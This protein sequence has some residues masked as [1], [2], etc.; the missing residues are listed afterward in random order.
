MDATSD[1]NPRAAFPILESLKRY[2]WPIPKR[3]FNSAC[4]GNLKYLC[5]E[6]C[7]HL[8]NVFSLSIA[9]GLVQLQKLE[10]DECDDMEGCFHKE[11]EDEKALNDNIMF[12]QL[13]SIELDSPPRLIGFCT[14]VGPTFNN[15]L[16]PFQN[17]LSHKLFLSNTIL[18]PPNLK[19]LELRKADSQEVV[20]DLKGLNINDNHQRI[21]VLAQL[22]TLEVKDLYKLT[23]VWKNVPIGIQ[24]FQ[25]L[26]SIEVSKCHRLKDIYSQL[27][28]QNCLWNFKALRRRGNGI[29]L[30]PRVGSLK[31]QELP[32]M[33]SLCIKTYSFEWSSIKEIYLHRSP[34][35]KQLVQKFRAK[36]D[37]K[38]SNS[39]K[40]SEIWSFFPSHI[41]ECLKNL[42][43]IELIN[44][45]SLEVL[46]QLEELN[47]E[48]NQW[49]Q[50]LIS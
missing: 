6:K 3:S 33:M 9:R 15:I 36:K 16:A 2:I 39:D 22:K 7:Q 24:G 20:F 29:I 46:F 45:P 23:Y 25:K 1:Q 37:P 42:E 19:Y 50:Y 35:L 10:I 18:W 49:H 47:V 5:L 40:S 26:T 17:Q 28:L 4:F 21:I 34:K 44:V 13:T 14:S 31:L 11:G 41:I 43:S 27:L 12:P 38:V 8:K 48:E 32:N 30:F